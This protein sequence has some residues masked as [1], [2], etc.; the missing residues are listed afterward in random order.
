MN[1]EL[2]TKNTVIYSHY[3][4]SKFILKVVNIVKKQLLNNQTLLCSDIFTT[5]RETTTFIFNC[6]T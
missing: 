4:V 2:Q 6:L 5:L 3:T 1:N